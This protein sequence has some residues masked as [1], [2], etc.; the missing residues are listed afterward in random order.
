VEV[1]P[2]SIR[3]RKRKLAANDRYKDDRDRKREQEAEADA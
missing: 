3:L 1:T 2:K